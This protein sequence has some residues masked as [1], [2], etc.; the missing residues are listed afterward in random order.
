M[1]FSKGTSLPNTYPD[2]FLT[3]DLFTDQN[4]H[5][6]WPVHV[7][8]FLHCRCDTEVFNSQNGVDP[9]GLEVHSVP[10]NIVRS[11][12]SS[13]STLSAVLSQYMCE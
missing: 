5:R 12:Q 2:N 11:R 7:Q 9:H 13:P 4:Y 10:V 6:L 3:A 8:T 1:T